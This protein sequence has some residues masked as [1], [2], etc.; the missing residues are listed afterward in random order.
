MQAGAPG[1]PAAGGEASATAPSGGAPRGERPR[2]GRRDARDGRRE[3]GPARDGNRGRGGEA[4]GPRPDPRGGGRGSAGSTGAAGATG[5][6]GGNDASE[7]DD[8]LSPAEAAAIGTSSF[9]GSSGSG[10]EPREAAIPRLTDRAG[11]RRAEPSWDEDEE[12]SPGAEAKVDWGRDDD[13]PAKALALPPSLPAEPDDELDPSTQQLD[14]AT[15]VRGPRG[16]V[17]GVVGVR[18]TPAGRVSMFET[19]P[20]F[21]AAGEQVLVDGERGP[22]V[23]IV[24]VAS[25]RRLSNDRGLRRVLRHATAADVEREAPG[26]ERVRTALRLAKDRTAALNL[27]VKV[28]RA[29]LVGGSGG[30]RNDK[31]LLYITTEERIDLRDLVRD[32]SNATNARVEL[33]QLGARDEAKA[34]GGIGS[35]GLTLCC[36]TWLPEFVPVSIKMAKDQGLV[37]NPTKVAGQCG[38]LKC[39]LVYEQAGYAEMRKGLPKLGKRV[40]TTRGEGRVVEVDVLRQRVR[41]S[42]GPGE[43][44]VMPAGDVKPLFPSGNAP[45]GGRRDDDGEG[46]DATGDATGDESLD[47]PMPAAELAAMTD[48]PAP[49]SAASAPELDPELP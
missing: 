12:P 29:E 9:G 42:Y 21:Y 19:G 23:G 43:S 24:A 3:G 8:D 36:T 5:A 45:P 40:I 15:D 27:P 2:D 48:E 18:F 4:R 17:V 34:I 39:C 13:G 32:L 31:L 37:L 47:A 20:A 7:L 49:A 44:E 22:R 26:A 11:D 38:R 46:G 16:D 1:L 25:E 10:G 14:E 28:F 30:G 41:V 33:R 6:T 35:C